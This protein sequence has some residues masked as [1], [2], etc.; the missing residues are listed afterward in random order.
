MSI[1]IGHVFSVYCFLL[2]LADVII[3]S[4]ED[5]LC[6]LRIDLLTWEIKLVKRIQLKASGVSDIAIRQDGRI[7]AVAGW[8]HTI[9][10]F[11]NKTCAP[12]AVLQVLQN[13]LPLA[14]SHLMQE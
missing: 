10:V 14:T 7:L 6:K 8:D 5:S 9:R 1:C 11:S 3:G 2:L 4:A 12:L 13:S